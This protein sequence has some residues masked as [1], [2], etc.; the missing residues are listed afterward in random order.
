[1]RASW[2]TLENFN[3]FGANDAGQVNSQRLYT[4][5]KVLQVFYVL[6]VFYQK[7]VSLIFLL[8]ALIKLASFIPSMLVAGT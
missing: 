8:L 7:T 2:Q 3:F 6:R 1:M 4:L 5:A